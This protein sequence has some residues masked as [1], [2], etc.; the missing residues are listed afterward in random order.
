MQSLSVSALCKLAELFI[1]KSNIFSFFD[2]AEDSND[3]R[4][5]A[6]DRAFERDNPHQAKE[7]I[8]Q[9]EVI[10]T[11]LYSKFPDLVRE[12]P[13]GSEWYQEVSNKLIAIF[14]KSKHQLFLATFLKKD[15]IIPKT[16][17]GELK[18]EIMRLYAK[19]NK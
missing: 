10:L 15:Q 4:D 19:R 3:A 11:S 8:S 12:L 5:H 17:S 2:F 9:A 16:V 6:K 14:K 13:E 7:A 1:K 18:E